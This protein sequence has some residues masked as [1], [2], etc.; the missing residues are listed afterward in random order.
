VTSGYLNQPA[1]NADRFVH[2][3]GSTE[4]WYRTGDLVREDGNRCLHYVGRIDNQVKVRGF[5]VELQEI[6][7]ALRRAAGTEDAIALAWPIRNGSA[8]GIIAFVAGQS[9]ETS[10]IMA[11]CRASLPAYMVPSAIHLIDRLPLNSNGKIDRKALA[12]RLAGED[13]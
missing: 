12:Q 1:L 13:A 11:E 7:H 5:R 8:D 10:R 4:R 6:D 2:V 9:V 3:P